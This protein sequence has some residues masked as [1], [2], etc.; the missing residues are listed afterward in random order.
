MFYHTR[1]SFQILLLDNKRSMNVNIFLKQFK[2]GHK[3][4]ISMIE[5]GDTNVIGQE[6]LLGLQKILPEDD[7]V[8]RG[9][10]VTLSTV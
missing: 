7:E 8:R 6:R 9:Y 5:A 4:I 1:F 3:E 2:C 10:H